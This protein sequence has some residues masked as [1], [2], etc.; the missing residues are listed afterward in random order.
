[1]ANFKFD[2]INLRSS[3]GSLIAKV[4]GKSIRD[5]HNSLIGKTDGQ[6]IRD[7]HN[8]IAC[9]IDGDNIQSAS[10][11]RIG[12]TSDIRNEI[13]GAGQGPTAVA[14]WWFFCR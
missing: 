11:S 14:L 7:S 2:G 10:N 4:D 9:R 8:S 12:K 5:S 6:T 3:S 1:M 13:D